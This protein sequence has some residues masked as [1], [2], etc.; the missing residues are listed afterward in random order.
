VRSIRTECLDQMIFVGRASL[1]RTLGKYVAHY[2]GER[3]HRGLGNEIPARPPARWEGPNQVAERLGGLF[4]YYHR[5]A[6]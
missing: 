5:A 2:D 3:S 4:R 6:A 1:E